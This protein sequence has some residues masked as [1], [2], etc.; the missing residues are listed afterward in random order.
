MIQ[1]VSR[2]LSVLVLGVTLWAAWPV[3]NGGRDVMLGVAPTLVFI[4][5]PKH[6]DEYTF[7]MWTKGYR[8]DAHTPAVFIAAVGWILLLVSASLVISP[9]LVSHLFGVV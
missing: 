8:I 5:F 1:F 2:A 7:G 4:W 6:I 3:Q 9:E